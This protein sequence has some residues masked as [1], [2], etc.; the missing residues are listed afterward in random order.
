VTRG[1]SRQFTPR[2]GSTSARY[3]LDKVPATLWKAAR[4]RAKREGL[5]MRALLLHLLTEW[6]DSP[7]GPTP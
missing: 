6:L 2:A 3:L 1:Y 5:S 4:A 7:E